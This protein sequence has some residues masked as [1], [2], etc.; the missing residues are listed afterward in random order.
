[1]YER[2]IVK[3]TLGWTE[4]TACIMLTMRAY[5]ANLCGVMLACVSLFVSLL[6][7]CQ[8][9]ISGSYLASDKSAVIWL[10]VVRTP[11]KHLTGQLAANVLK[12]DGSIEQNSVSISGAVDGEN[13]TIQGSRFFGLESFVLSGTLS[14]NV[15][16]LTGAQSVPLTFTRSTPAEFQARVA[17]LNARSQSITQAKAVAQAQQRTFQAQA[18]FVSQVDQLIRRMAQFDSQADVHL[19]RFPGAEKGY[20]GITAR[21]GEYVARERRLA[22]NPNAEVARGQ[23][24]VAA[25]QASIQTDRMHYQGESLQSSLET[26]VKPMAD[27]ATAFEQQ[28]RAVSQNSGHLTPAEVQNVNA[29]CGRLDSAV[30]PFRQKFSAMSAGLAH[31]EQV[32]QDEHGRQQQLLQTAQ[33]LE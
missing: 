30:G 27:Q 7:G 5:K 20:E 2:V 18:N 31:L 32:Y 6:T 22:G 15:L 23:L 16:T 29:A 24:S 8:R 11:D 10:Q 12:P 13:V 28:C 9:N 33:R 3:M 25:N 4:G 21:V 26:N 19:G 1:V 17:A 14:G